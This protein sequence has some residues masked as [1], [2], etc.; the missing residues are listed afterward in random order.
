MILEKADRVDGT[1]RENT[2]PG[3]ACDVPSHLY[4]FSFAPN[5][6][7]SRAYGGQTEILAYLE[8]CLSS[9]DVVG[10]GGVHLDQA[11]RSSLRNYLGIPV[12]GFPNMFLL[13]G[14]NTGLGH[15]SMVFMI[16]AQAQARH[17]TRAIEALRDRKLAFIDVRPA[18][19]QRFRAELARKTTGTVWTTGRAGT[20]RPAARCS[21]GRAPR[22]M[23]G[24]ARGGSISTTTSSA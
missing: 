15:N 6:T 1:W 5:P 4:S 22:S 21:C 16:E 19:E 14:P 7:W 13:M 20:R 24:G 17:A 10:R 8:R 12:S 9:I 3:T 11:W 23:T 18:I 2:Y